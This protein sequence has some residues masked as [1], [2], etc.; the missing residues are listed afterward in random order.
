MYMV[1]E[2]KEI[3]SAAV[4][5]TCFLTQLTD[6]TGV[7]T[8][9]FAPKVLVNRIVSEMPTGNSAIFVPTGKEL[10]GIKSYNT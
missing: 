1:I 9:I 2:M 4:G 6:E 7:K 5:T 10:K 3:Y 8:K